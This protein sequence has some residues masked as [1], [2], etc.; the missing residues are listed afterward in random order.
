VASLLPFGPFLID[1]V[2]VK[3]EAKEISDG[4]IF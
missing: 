4:G 1:R 3:D 2:L